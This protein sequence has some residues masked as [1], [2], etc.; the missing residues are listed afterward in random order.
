MPEKEF[1]SKAS[2]R[3][4]YYLP[5]YASGLLL[6]RNVEVQFH[7]LSSSTVYQAIQ[8]STFSTELSAGG[9]WSSFS[10]SASG[11]KSETFAKVESSDTGLRIKIPGVQVIGYYT[12]NIPLFPKP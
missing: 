11:S 4:R 1:V 3:S 2:D 10:S 7:E 8:Q 12:Q 5:H 6:S 9:F